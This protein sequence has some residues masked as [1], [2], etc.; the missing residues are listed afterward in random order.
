MQ[1]TDCD[2]NSHFYDIMRSHYKQK[3]PSI[4][5]P[6]KLFTKEAQKNKFT[7]KVSITTNTAYLLN[8]IFKDREAEKFMVHG[9]LAEWTR[10][11]HDRENDEVVKH[12]NKPRNKKQKFKNEF[13]R[14]TLEVITK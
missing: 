4:K 6:S 7:K 8:M 13:I 9:K 12:W 1:C 2:F 11:E 5:Y 14:V 3:H 10:L